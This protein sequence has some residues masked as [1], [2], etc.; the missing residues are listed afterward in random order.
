MPPMAET[1]IVNEIYR[2]LSG[3][4]ATAG[5]LCVIVRLTGC[6]LRCRW[7]D[8][9]HAHDEGRE[10][11][12]NRIGGMVWTLK[13]PLVLVTGGEP[14]AQPGT[15]ELLLTLCEAG[16]RVRLETNGSMDLSGV[17]LR[18]RKC[19]DV[20]CPGSGQEGSFL[21]SN[22]KHLYPFDEVKFVIADYDDF[23]YA[24]AFANEHVSITLADIIFTP[25]AGELPAAQLAEWML[26]DGGLPPRARLGLQ[27]HKILWP[28][29][30]RGV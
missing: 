10:I 24:V 19:V 26:N 25:V 17:D 27:L 21:L 4:G 1:L 14:L 15:P 8:T 12:V 9:P 30:E 6:N 3:E 28:D 18:V 11:S 16:R 13:A 20:K 22:L 5:Q 7:C 29:V 23:K 2:T